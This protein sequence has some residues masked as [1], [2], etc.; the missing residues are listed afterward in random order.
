MGTATGPDGAQC[1]TADGTWNKPAGLIY[2][3]RQGARNG[4]QWRGTT[5]GWRGSGAGGYC[6]KTLPRLGDGQRVTEAYDLL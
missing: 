3:R 5:P 1:L 6:R 4:G 2:A